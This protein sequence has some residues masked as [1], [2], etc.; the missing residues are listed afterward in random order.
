MFDQVLLSQLNKAPDWSQQAESQAAGSS[1]SPIS[2]LHTVANP[3]SVVLPADPHGL[4]LW[5][6]RCAGHAE[7]PTVSAERAEGHLH[8]TE[9]HARD[10]SPGSLSGSLTL[11]ACIPWESDTMFCQVHGTQ[12]VF[13]TTKKAR[14]GLAWYKEYKD[15]TEILA[16]VA[17]VTLKPR[18]LN[19]SLPSAQRAASK[20]T[21][22]W[23]WLGT[24]PRV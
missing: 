14:T 5:P 9:P 1:R 3:G 2:W 22:T 23:Q 13:T 15:R 16:L 21:D 18:I 4:L 12:P 7:P 6:L 10:P 11:P 19:L 8:R 20:R 24:R 17:K